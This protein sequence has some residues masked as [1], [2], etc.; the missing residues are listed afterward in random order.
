MPSIIVMIAVLAVIAGGVYYIAN[1]PANDEAMMEEK[2]AEMMMKD[3][4]TESIM[5]AEPREDAMMKDIDDGVMKEMMTMTYQYFGQLLDVTDGKTIRGISTGGTSSGVAKANFQDGTY[6]LVVTFENLPDPVGSDFYEGW[7]VQRGA[8]LDVI[9]TGKVS[10]VD[11]AYT[12]SYR[13]GEDFSNYDF[14]VLT[15]E[16]DDGNPAPADHI[17][18]GILSQ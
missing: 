2:N 12:N 15:I 18:E 16:P 4:G 3:N 5:G 8:S 17:L 10:K 14:Y 6:D 9:S 7:I 11:G 1:Q 13:S